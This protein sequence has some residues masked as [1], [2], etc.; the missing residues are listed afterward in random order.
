MSSLS[1]VIPTWNEAALIGDAVTCA[2]R[3]ADE[4]IVVDGHSDDG[5]LVLAEAAGA[6][7]IV[8]NKGRGG[9]LHAGALA[10]RGDI[11][12]FLHADARLPSSARD[13]ILSGMA[14]P[15]C[16]G[17]NFFIEFLP[18][19]WFTRLLAPLN[20]LRRRITRRY[21][22]DSGIF[23]RRRMY[24]QLGGYPP[25]PLMED[26]AFSRR[27][28]QAGPCMY[29]RDIHVLASARRFDGREIRTL[30]LWM[31]LQMLYWLGVSPR[32]I[33]KAYPD[34][35]SDHPGRFIASC[36]QRFGHAGARPPLQ[37]SSGGR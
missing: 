25:F 10:A 1:I 14:D 2:R 19:S 23:V 15:D 6:R 36:R 21:Y 32:L 37:L 26:Y 8:S 35:R 33:D 13:A 17:G 28:E 7:V 20:D 4:V 24:H 3:I 27:M 22:G 18:A 11:L 9:Q 30:F 34:V 29:I 12:L 31:G 16:I 5:T